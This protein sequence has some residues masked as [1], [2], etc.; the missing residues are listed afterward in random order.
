MPCVGDHYEDVAQ[1]V[2]VDH[3]R[4]G[5]AASE[6]NLLCDAQILRETL[7]AS[8]VVAVT[9]HEVVEPRE[10]TELR[11]HPD[12]TLDPLVARAGREAA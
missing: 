9:G 10:I 12:D 5:H 7:K 2:D 3:V 11:E 1:V 8:A 6:V 4:L